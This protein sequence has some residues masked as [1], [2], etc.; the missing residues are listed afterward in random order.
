MLLQ[1]YKVY[2]I[3]EHITGVQVIMKFQVFI[4][5]IGAGLADAFLYFRLNKVQISRIVFLRQ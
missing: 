3:I 4:R 1:T 2:V 5:I